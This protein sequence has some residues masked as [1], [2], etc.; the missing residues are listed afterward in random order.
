MLLGEHVGSGEVS[1]ERTDD[2]K[3]NMYCLACLGA[4]EPTLM[5]TGRGA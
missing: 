5:I 3:H 2:A 4:E 1:V